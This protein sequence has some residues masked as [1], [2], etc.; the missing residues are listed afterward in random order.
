ML[1]NARAAF[2]ISVAVRVDALYVTV[3]ATRAPP[4][5]RKSNVLAVMV[6]GSTG[7]LKVAVSE[8]VTLT[9]VAPAA[10]LIVVTVGGVV[11]VGNVVANTTSTQ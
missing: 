6:A 3:A 2:G 5:S 7:S 8:V 9:L 11:S 1:L 10:G 4:P